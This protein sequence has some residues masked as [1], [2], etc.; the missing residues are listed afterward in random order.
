MTL[1]EQY[2]S[3]TESGIHVK[4]FADADSVGYARPAD[5]KP[6]CWEDEDGSKPGKTKPGKTKPGKTKCAVREAKAA[7]LAQVQLAQKNKRQRQQ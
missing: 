1:W 4:F 6:F 7:Q 5:V 3:L 2:G